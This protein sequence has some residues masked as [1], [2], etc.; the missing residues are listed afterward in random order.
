[1]FG[2]DPPS[3]ALHRP[4]PMLQSLYDLLGMPLRLALL[5]DHRNERL[6]LTSLR[7]ERLAKVLPHLRGR[8]LD[9]GAGDNMLIRLYRARQGPAESTPGAAESVGLDVIDWGGGCQI[10]PDCRSLPYA[11][12]SFDT[13]TVV[14]CLNHIPERVEA[15]KEAH[16]ILKPGGRLIV[17]MIGKVIGEVGHAVWW[18]SEDKHRDVEEGEVMGMN[19]R[20][21]IAL[22]DASGFSRVAHHRFLYGLN[23]L[24]LAER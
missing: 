8:V 18:Y 14:A 22:L 13:V 6:H 2:D 12:A 17:T 21:I 10:V 16:R 23:S 9:I 11:D 5:P 3:W 20:D 15:L 19:P 24:Y 4:K 7:A 1:M